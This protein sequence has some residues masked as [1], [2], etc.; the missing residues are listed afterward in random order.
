VIAGLFSVLGAV[1]FGMG[2]VATQVS[3]AQPS[4]RGLATTGAVLLVSALALRRLQQRG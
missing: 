4:A 2:L 3:Y 1:F